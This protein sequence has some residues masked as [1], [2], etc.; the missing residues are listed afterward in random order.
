[1]SE[2]ATDTRIVG[3]IEWFDLHDGRGEDCQCARCGS[4]CVF[5]D[6]ANC[7]EEGNSHHS[8]GE[9]TCCCLYPD[10]NVR[11]DWCH[12][13]GGWWHCCSSPAWCEANP[14]PG[15]EHIKSTAM[16]AEAWHD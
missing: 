16:E 1:V 5:L 10:N 2:T 15:R 9:D 3:G 12:G 8:C 7:D 6:C 13:K 4:S 14:M 11:C